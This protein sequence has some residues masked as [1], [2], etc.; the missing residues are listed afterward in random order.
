MVW[1]QFDNKITRVSWDLLKQEVLSLHISVSHALD[2]KSSQNK[3]S[4]YQ[5]VKSKESKSKILN[6]LM[7]TLIEPVC[8]PENRP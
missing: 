8:H 7:L 1:V 3:V 6:I 5:M 4:T 2:Y